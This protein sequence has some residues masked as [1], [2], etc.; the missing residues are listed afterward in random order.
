MTQIAPD[1]AIEQKIAAPDDEIGSDAHKEIRNSMMQTVQ[2][3][4]LWPTSL[5]RWMTF[6]APIGTEN[7]F[8]NRLKMSVTFRHLLAYDQDF[9][10]A[11]KG[12]EKSSLRANYPSAQ[13]AVC[14]VDTAVNNAA[15]IS[16]L[17]LGV[18][19]GILGSMSGNQDGW[20]DLIG[21]TKT[22]DGGRCALPYSDFCFEYLFGRYQALYLTSTICFYSAL[23]TLITAIVYYL[24]RPSESSNV[25]SMNVLL[26]ACTLEIRKEIREHRSGSEDQ[27]AVDPAIPFPTWGEELEVFTKA[28]FMAKHE[29]A[30]QMNME[31]YVW[32]RRGRFLVLGMFLG[33]TCTI[34]C[35]TYAVNVFVLFWFTV[36]SDQS[37]VPI[38]WRDKFFQFGWNMNWASNFIGYF[39]VLFSWY[40]CV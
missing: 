26:R 39:F 37:K 40:I 13:I 31:F 22:P 15:L 32:Y 29:A 21:A 1:V 35:A 18:P 30:E 6:L 8:W 16:A 17:M 38:D 5:F 7:C 24:C 3:G 27:K 33:L 12:L 19:M 2:R 28:K 20:L 10:A 14:D 34:V 11:L 36:T 25:S 9:L 4:H 23:F